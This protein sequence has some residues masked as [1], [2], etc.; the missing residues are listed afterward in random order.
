MACKDVGSAEQNMRHFFQP[1]LSQTA[2]T[3]DICLV[4]G[5]MQH[6]NNFMELIWELQLILVNVS[7]CY[8]MEAV[9]DSIQTFLP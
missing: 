4:A 3:R 6:F 2:S 7:L 8:I 1:L 9:N 5:L